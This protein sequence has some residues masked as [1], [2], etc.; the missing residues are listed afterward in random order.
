MLRRTNV[1]VGTTVPGQTVERESQVDE[2]RRN[3]AFDALKANYTSVS[4]KDLQKGWSQRFN[5]LTDILT[6]EGKL[7]VIQELLTDLSADHGGM[8]VQLH[9]EEANTKLTTHR[10]NELM[11]RLGQRMAALLPQIHVPL[12]IHVDGES[13]KLLLLNGIKDLLDALYY[14][15]DDSIRALIHSKIEEIRGVV[16]KRAATRLPVFLLPGGGRDSGR[17]S[18]P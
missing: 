16:K 3:D 13:K 2:V 12:Q 10:R 14:Y 11:A 8:R 5:T 18:G 17:G 1:D 6:P 15:S 7:E 4:K 9:A